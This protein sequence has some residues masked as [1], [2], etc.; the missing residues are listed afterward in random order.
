MTGPKS[1]LSVSNDMSALCTDLCT[2]MHELDKLIDLI[3]Y[4]M[5]AAQKPSNGKLGVVR[6]KPLAGME[7]LGGQPRL[8]E[9]QWVRSG[10]FL[11]FKLPMTHIRK[12]VKSAAP[13]DQS[14]EIMIALARYLDTAISIRTDLHKRY[15]TARKALKNLDDS[16]DT[17]RAMTAAMTVVYED[18]REILESGFEVSAESLGYTLNGD[19]RV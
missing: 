8:A 11:D 4:A 17:I 10:K 3:R 9:K 7:W 1:Y 19:K 18:A 2:Q 5:N 16:R 6:E 12:R 14:Y 15:A 13:F